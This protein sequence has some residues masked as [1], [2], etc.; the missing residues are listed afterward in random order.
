MQHCTNQGDVLMAQTANDRNLPIEMLDVL[1]I[2]QV[3]LL[4]SPLLAIS[5]SDVPNMLAEPE[6][7]R[8]T[9]Y[10]GEMI[11]GVLIGISSEERGCTCL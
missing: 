1:L 11:S 6:D 5:V 10:N 2:L 8:N 3:E 9:R 7:G 4:E